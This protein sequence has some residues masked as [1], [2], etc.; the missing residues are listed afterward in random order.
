MENFIALLT[1]YRLDLANFAYPSHLV[2]L[3]KV[4]PF[5]FMK[6]LYGF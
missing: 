1:S 3:F 6:K 2:L 5:E 4:T